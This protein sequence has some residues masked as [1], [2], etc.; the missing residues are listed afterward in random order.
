MGC[1]PPSSHFHIILVVSLS[2]LIQRECAH[3]G[4]QDRGSVLIEYGGG[5]GVPGGLIT[6]RRHG[7]APRLEMPHY[8]DERQ[9]SA[10]VVYNVNSSASVAV[11]LV[12]DARRDYA[13]ILHAQASD[14]PLQIEITSVTL[15]VWERRTSVVPVSRRIHVSVQTA[16]SRSATGLGVTSKEL[17]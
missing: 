5:R 7:H 3:T 16:K 14:P 2:L 6:A 11:Y 17:N 4:P 15:H 9:K 8:A 1:T 10:R 13:R 12:T